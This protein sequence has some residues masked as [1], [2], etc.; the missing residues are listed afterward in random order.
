[1]TGFAVVD[2]VAIGTWRPIFMWGNGLWRMY[3]Q[4]QWQGADIFGT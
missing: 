3:G 1:M 4:K 2:S